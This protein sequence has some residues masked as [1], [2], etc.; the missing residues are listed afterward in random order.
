[1]GF[2]WRQIC[3]M[4][5]YQGFPSSSLSPALE[6]DLITS[7]IPRAC[8]EST[9]L[10]KKMQ[11]LEKQQ[12]KDNETLHVT[13]CALQRKRLENRTTCYLFFQ[14]AREKWRAISTCLTSFV[15]T[16][17]IPLPL[18]LLNLAFLDSGGILLGFA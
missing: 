17:F 2:K 9:V 18:E 14:D 10:S 4:L 5:K 12:N 13:H 8:G 3:K 11:N 6:F 16:D 15:Y 1:M 7:L